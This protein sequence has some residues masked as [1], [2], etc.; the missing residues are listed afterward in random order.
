MPV[1]AFGPRVVPGPL[2]RRDTFADLGA[3]VADWFGIA[4]RGTGS[5]FLGTLL[6]P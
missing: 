5:S 2:G 4:F 3:T 6:T 1:L